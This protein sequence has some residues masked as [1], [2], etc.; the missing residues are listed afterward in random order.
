[1]IDRT[2]LT[3]TRPWYTWLIS[4]T[5]RVDSGGRRLT[6]VGL[7]DQAAAIGT[8]AI[9]V[10]SL[11]GGLYRV[12]GYLRVTQAA[13]TSSS[14]ALTLQWTDG[15][16]GCTAVGTAV[17]GNT[18]AATQSVSVLLKVDQASPISYSTSYASVG[19]T[20]MK[21]GIDLVLEVVA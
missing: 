21:Y 3:I 17:T 5:D 11:A 19:A 10:G 13:T 20:V 12:S 1:V 18:T 4:L 16:V 9:P 7:T 2:D 8:T 14:V 6:V 15:G